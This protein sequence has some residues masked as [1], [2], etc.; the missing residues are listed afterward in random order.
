MKAKFIIGCSETDSNLY[1][2]TR[3][4][5]PDEF[6]CL[7]I[8]GRRIAYV[9]DMEFTR[10]EAEARVD[11]VV[12]TSRRPEK[13]A[14]TLEWMVAERKISEAAVPENFAIVQAERLRKMGVKVEVKAGAYFPERE[15]KDSREIAHIRA[16]Q[17]VNEKALAVALETL[18]RSGIRQDGK[19]EY[20]GKILTSEFLKEIIGIEF[21]KGGCR[22][23]MDIVACGRQSAQPHNSGSGPLFAHQPIVIDLYPRSIGSRYYADMTRTVVRGKAFPETKKMFDAVLVAQKAALEKVRAGIRIS[24]LEKEARDHFD[25]AGFPTVT[26]SKGSRGFIHNLGHG[27]GLDIHEGPTV[28]RWNNHELKAGSVITI[29]PGLY[30]PQVGGIRIEDMVVVEEGGCE[31]LT[32]AAKVLEIT[33][34]K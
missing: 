9:N 12:N 23:K 3:F 10:A 7:E 11:E 34:N 30:Y 13:Y 29:E 27:V 25:K 14:S 16:A 22:S 32:R 4:L 31:N 24:A 19:L 28:N 15:V 33:D 26:D 6:I 20:D 1:Y 21:L 5:A 18:R 2:A 17:R 8:G